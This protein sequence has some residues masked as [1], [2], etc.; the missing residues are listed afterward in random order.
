[1][2]DLLVKLYELTGTPAEIPGIEIRRPMPHENG[3]VKRWIAATF[4]EV[5]GEE[6]ECNLK[7]FPV[8][9]F[10][11]LRNGKIVG[12]ACYDVTCRGYFGPTGVHAGSLGVT[13]KVDAA[14][15]WRARGAA[16]RRFIAPRKKRTSF[17][18]SCFRPTLRGWAAEEL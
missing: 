13:R 1:V 9:S 2:T 15:C 5:W 8:T 17:F 3:T 18:H 7:S 11:A 16:E 14:S 6:F 10:I 4:S 12:F